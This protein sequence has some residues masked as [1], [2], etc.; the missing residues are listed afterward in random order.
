MFRRCMARGEQEQDQVEEESWGSWARR[1]APWGVLWYVLGYQI[2][3]DFPDLDPNIK[4]EL[5]LRPSQAVKTM[6][7][8]LHPG[9]SPP[10]D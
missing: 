4:R 5:D 2:P 7:S 3:S 6:R 9:H 8:R 1:I 10:W